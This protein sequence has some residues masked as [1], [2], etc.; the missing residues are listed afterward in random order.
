MVELEHFL[1]SSLA[2]EPCLMTS[3][4]LYQIHLNGT[5]NM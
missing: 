1:S 4:E 3:E 2:D 5:Y